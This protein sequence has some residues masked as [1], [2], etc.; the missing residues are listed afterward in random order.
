MPGNLITKESSLEDAFEV[1]KTINEFNGLENIGELHER[2][3]KNKKLIV[4]TYQDNLPIGY[5]IAYDRFKDG[6]I[7]CWLAG[8]NKYHRRHGVLMSL[9]EYQNSW[10][11]KQGYKS[12]RITTRNRFRGMLTYL[13]KNGFNI[14]EVLYRNDVVENK[15]RFIKYI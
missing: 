10:A 11:N 2:L 9:M 3:G 8:V 1:H 12:I 4:V 15:I 14:T 13:I 6:S 5:L 7:Y